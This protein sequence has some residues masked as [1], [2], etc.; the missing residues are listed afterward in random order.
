MIRSL[1]RFGQ[2]VSSSVWSPDGESFVT[3]CLDKE[4]N[5]C[6]WNINGDLIYDWGRSHRIQDLAVS[7]DGHRLVGMDNSGKIYVYNF[8]TRELDYE[9]DFKIQLSSVSIAQD[10]KTLLILTVDGDARL[11]DLDSRETVRV[12]R[13]GEEKTRSV[14]KAA[15]GGANESFIITGSESMYLFF[16][17]NV[18]ADHQQQVVPSTSGIETRV[19]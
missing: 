7:P 18:L 5:L 4:R 8:V 10:S 13:S 15:F 3:G 14:I 6:Q 11:I 16:D 1:T 2:P 9:V 12:F 17:L 19:L